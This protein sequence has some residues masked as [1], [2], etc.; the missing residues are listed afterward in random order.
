M[1]KKGKGTERYLWVLLSCLLV[2]AAVSV[3]SYTAMHAQSL[4]D[5]DRIRTLY[6]ER[7]EN[8]INS[9]FHKT[10]VLA[11]VVKLRNGDITE[12]IFDEIAGIVYT[13]KSGIR[14]IQY[15]PN[16][17]VTYSYPL[18]GNEA[19]MGKNFLEIP[20]RRNDC[21]LAI[22]TKSIALSGPY[23]LIQGGLGLVAR[24]PIFLTNENGEEYFW[25]FSAI[26]LDLPG[27]LGSVGLDSLPESGY[28]F[29]LSCV[30]EN[31]EKLV[32]EGNENLDTSKA[33]SGIIQVPN[34]E[35]NLYIMELYP[36][37][38]LLRALLIM[39]AGVML[40]FVLW[41]LYGTLRREK[42]A[43]R[44]K[45]QFFSDIS[46]DMRTPLNAIIG[47][48]T[49]A[50]I[51]GTKPEEKDSYLEKIRSSGKMMLDLVN[52]TLTI[53]K[54][55]NGKLRMHPEPSDTEDLFESVLA[56]IQEMA[57][58]KDILFEIDKT[59]YRP[60][61]VLVDR[62]SFQKIFLNLFN[63]AVKFTPEGGHVRFA[64][65]DDPAGSS[66]PDLVF[67]AADNGIGMSRGYM[68]KMY[69]PFSQEQREGY[70]GTGTGLGLP[71]VRRIVE[72]MGGTIRA[73]S[74]VGKGTVFTVRLHLKETDPVKEP[75]SAPH[76]EADYSGL[77]GKK[78]LLCEDNETNR[79]IASA[80]LQNVGMTV[81]CAVNGQVGVEKF[82]LSEIGEFSVILMDLRMPVM[83]GLE[84]AQAIRKLDRADAASVPIL[85]MSADVFEDDIRKCLNAGMNGHIPKP[86]DPKNLYQTICSHI[87][88]LG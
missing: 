34:H 3:L 6:A 80:L 11:A 66:D 60:R 78:A 27:A 74:V 28:D 58:R 18:I 16:A 46:H 67:T 39:A 19:V 30:N 49:L 54:S 26:V 20:E 15:M 37:S 53:S 10:D 17:I 76:A 43:L 84:A 86:V 64:V 21:L 51:S 13:D 1:K 63:N 62:L 59:A 79:Q 47:F 72:M 24:N 7:T 33:V 55:E 61:T 50:Q 81:S 23:N 75:A 8:Y 71:I 77:S 32:I 40:S 35:W 5:I 65:R 69:E 56:P 85:A 70:E 25:G 2:S 36:W 88:T 4:R 73:E 31:G 14:G 41:R 83:D 38:N 82:S 42:A 68:E 29:Q 9:V 44:A 57:D 48:S 87:H 52:D 12:D 22:Q 45:D